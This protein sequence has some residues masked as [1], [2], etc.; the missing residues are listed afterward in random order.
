MA[1]LQGLKEEVEACERS[2]SFAQDQLKMSKFNI[3]TVSGMISNLKPEN[4]AVLSSAGFE[5]LDA[6]LKY[7]ENLFHSA[8]ETRQSADHAV[9]SAWKKL[10]DKRAQLETAQTAY[11][12]LVNSFQVKISTHVG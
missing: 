2:Y 4:L 3:D 1:Y 6:L 10:K 12:R 11:S 8:Y 9:K 7:R 5:S